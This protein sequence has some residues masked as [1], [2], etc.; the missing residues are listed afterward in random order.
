M[1]LSDDG[2]TS[3][4]NTSMEN[5]AAIAGFLDDGLRDSPWGPECGRVDAAGMDVDEGS[6]L[7]VILHSPLIPSQWQSVGRQD[8]QLD[9]G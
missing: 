3:L 5:P 7:S 8:F 6:P 2:T 4:S 1:L 9:R